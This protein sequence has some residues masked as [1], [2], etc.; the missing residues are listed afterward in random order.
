[1]CLFATEKWPATHVAAVGGGGGVILYLFST[2]RGP[3]TQV[4]VVAVVF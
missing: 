2:E 4:V 3:A 1:M